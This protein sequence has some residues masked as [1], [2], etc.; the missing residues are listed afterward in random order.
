MQDNFSLNE[1]QRN[2]WKGEF[3]DLYVERNK[4]VEQVNTAFDEL[5]GITLET[6]LSTFFNDLSRHFHILEIG[7]NIGLNL[8]ILKNMGFENLYGV[9]INEKAINIAKQQNPD[10]TFFHS[11]IEKFETDQKFDLV[12]T[13]GVLIHVNPESL[14]S[15]NQKIYALTDKFIFGY[16]NFS[17]NLTRLD[18]RN[19]SN[20]LWKQNFSELY[21]KTFPNLIT[22]KEKI[23][24]YKNDNLKDIAF[25][26][27]KSD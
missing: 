20:I 19:H 27:K 7:C 21:R 17:E 1:H 24:P 26:L 4:T 10:I 12:F 18:Y 16:E 13:A 3:G 14:P 8:S 15:I 23:Y 6:L 25:L 2:T 5:M 22:I 11:S 9:E